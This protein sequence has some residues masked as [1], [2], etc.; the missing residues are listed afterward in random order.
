MSRH[1][2]IDK[3]NLRQEIMVLGI[4][5]INAGHIT[6]LANL[7]RLEQAIDTTGLSEI[8]FDFI[9]GVVQMANGSTMHWLTN[10]AGLSE[11][12]IDEALRII[13]KRM[14]F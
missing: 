3:S 14:R 12:L 9:K 2:D 13:K 10:E 7:I 11:G 8:P 1:I 4:S 6:S 5:K